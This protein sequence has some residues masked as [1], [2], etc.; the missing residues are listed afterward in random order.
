MVTHASSD[1]RR[2]QR[3]ARRAE[4][5]CEAIA[6][7]Q[8][9]SATDR[10]RVRMASP[11]EALLGALLRMERAW[12][13][14]APRRSA[15]GG[16]WWV[17]AYKSLGL[18]AASD[19]ASR[20]ESS[21]AVLRKLAAMMSTAIAGASSTP[22]AGSRQ[23]TPRQTVSAPAP[24]DNTSG[25]AMSSAT[26]ELAALLRVTACY[27]SHAGHRHSAAQ[28]RATLLAPLNEARRLLVGSAATAAATSLSTG[29]GAAER[30][31]LS[32]AL[33]QCTHALV[34]ST[35]RMLST[36]CTPQNA[37][38]LRSAWASPWLAAPAAPFT[39]ELV[40]R[41][42]VDETLPTDL[43]SAYTSS[44]SHPAAA[45]RALER[46]RTD[47]ARHLSLIASLLSPS[48]RLAISPSLID[49]P[50]S[51]NLLVA[52]VPIAS[53]ALVNTLNNN[54]LDPPPPLTPRTERALVE[55][56]AICLRERS[57]VDALPQTL[58]TE[59]LTTTF[60]RMA[61]LLAL[62]E[63]VLRGHV[64]AHMPTS[65][66][67]NAD[68]QQDSKTA[69][70][71]AEEEEESPPTKLPIGGSS[72]EKGATQHATDTA[73]WRVAA[74]REVAGVIALCTAH[75]R[76]LLTLSLHRGS[77]GLGATFSDLSIAQTLST[78]ISLEIDASRRRRRPHNTQRHPLAPQTTTR[79]IRIQMRRS[80]TPLPSRRTAESRR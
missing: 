12:P 49:E 76:L 34:H 69:R 17:H 15:S 7:I 37:A 22:R 50:A 57:C 18:F 62:G 63:D 75:G 36:G 29:P 1:R 53:R 42:L 64:E 27:I 74:K 43:Q 46:W 72:P 47:A 67:L 79:T 5:R 48:S 2:Q 8:A 4:L 19:A 30:L 23:Q 45:N 41:L 51:A 28:L 80:S 40:T 20:S 9:A 32:A 38:E 3:A 21:T 71:I 66:L 13:L 61:E 56:L 60:H 78:E 70:S 26:A 16:K 55:H 52:S 14:E 35:R 6:L 68:Q 39:M 33:L 59:L 44:S 54:S 31:G 73:A 65:S 77:H 24:A 58:A 10:V 25:G 11:V